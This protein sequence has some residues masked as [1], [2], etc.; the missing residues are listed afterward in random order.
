MFVY[1]GL[2]SSWQV[3]QLHE[4][5]EYSD[6]ACLEDSDLQHSTP[7]SYLHL[8]VPSSIFSESEGSGTDV[9]FRAVHPTVTLSTLDTY[10]SLLSQPST[11]KTKQNTKNKN[12]ASLTKTDSS[13]Y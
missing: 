10:K 8:S 11:A 1:S 2:C 6:Q 5:S 4:T 12:K 7:D 3:S 9:P 13:T